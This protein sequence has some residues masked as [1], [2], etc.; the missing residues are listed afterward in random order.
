MIG[1][2]DV[3]QLPVYL[4]QPTRDMFAMMLNRDALARPSALELLSMAAC[5][6]YFE[7]F[8]DA[9]S[10]HLAR[11]LL[12]NDVARIQASSD[13][14]HVRHLHGVDSYESVPSPAVGRGPD[15]SRGGSNHPSDDRRTPRE[16]A[17]ANKRELADSKTA[18]LRDT[19]AKTQAANAISRERNSTR[20][21]PQDAGH[22]MSSSQPSPLGLSTQIRQMSNVSGEADQPRQIS[23]LS[24]LSERPSPDHWITEHPD[25]F[26]DGYTP[27]ETGSQATHKFSV[28]TAQT[29]SSERAGTV[30]SA[31]DPHHG[32]GPW[33]REATDSM[34]QSGSHRSDL[35][36]L[37]GELGTLLD[38]SFKAPRASPRTVQTEPALQDPAPR[39]YGLHRS[40]TER[41]V[42]DPAEDRPLLDATTT[43]VTQE[44]KARGDL[45]KKE[46]AK[47]TLI[48][49]VRCLL[50]CTADTA[51]VHGGRS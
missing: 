48:H 14:S 38:G 29:P 41:S 49:C 39:D 51:R 3:P 18:M 35:I 34:A 19:A 13:A 30:G 37:K 45:G 21:N 23:N 20:A 26:P 2:R 33:Q 4:S 1:H 17:A 42:Y 8:S 16:R 32:G 6:D 36:F 9:L 11:T 40:P 5:H 12:K 7:S 43:M 47:V 22:W 24:E 27:N 28:F 25:I 31:R 15:A 50:R 10:D 44:S 46:Y